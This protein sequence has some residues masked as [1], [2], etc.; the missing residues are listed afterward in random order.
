MS[1][2]V[3]NGLSKPVVKKSKNPFTKKVIQISQVG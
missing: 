3:L 2:N 1:R